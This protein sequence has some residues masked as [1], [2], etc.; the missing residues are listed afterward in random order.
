MPAE[1][2]HHLKNSFRRTYSTCYQG[3]FACARLLRSPPQNSTYPQVYQANSSTDGPYCEYTKGT[4]YSAPSKRGTS[5][6]KTP[7]VVIG[8]G[9]M[10]SV[11][12]RGLLR[13]GHP[14][15]PVTHQTCVADTAKQ[16]AEPEIVLLAVAEKDLHAALQN[17]PA[18]WRDRLVLL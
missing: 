6:V 14:V 4:L 9:E 8:I 17:I 5:F 13:V 16:I 12:S 11:F 1:L 18:I 2:T 10:G 15:Y 7:V 3:L